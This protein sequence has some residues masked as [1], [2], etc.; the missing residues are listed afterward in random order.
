[1]NQQQVQIEV[2]RRT[3]EIDRLAA[4]ISKW[5]KD[6]ALIDQLDFVRRWTNLSSLC[7]EWFWYP[8]ELVNLDAVKEEARQTVKRHIKLKQTELKDKTESLR[9]YIAEVGYG[10]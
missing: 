2:K 3:E 8:F 4:T 1:M 10:S 5:E 7:Y 6:Y 9:Q